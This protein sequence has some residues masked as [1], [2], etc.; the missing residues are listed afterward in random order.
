MSFN[1]APNSTPSASGFNP[2]WLIVGG[3]VVIAG[4]CLCLGIGVVGFIGYRAWQGARTTTLSLSTPT[5]TAAEEFPVGGIEIPIQSNAHIAIGAPHDPYN[6]EPPTS[7]PHYAQPAEAGFY[8]EEIPDEH[9]VHNLEHGYV[10][11]WYSC[12]QLSDDDCTNLQEHIRA[13]MDKAGN[14]VNT[15]TPKLIAVP[16][17]QLDT[18]LALTTWGRL[19]KFNAFDEDRILTFI[20]TYRDVAP[21][22]NVP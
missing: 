17:P 11:I 7:G 12:R 22:P 16:R 1:E 19:D 8:T 9:L 15:G 5:A 18:E 21:E 4:F 6:S 20:A 13:V 10:I 14:S 2:T 3:V